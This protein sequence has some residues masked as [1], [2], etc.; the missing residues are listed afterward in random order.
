MC[1]QSVFKQRV[2]PGAIVCEHQINRI[3]I[4]KGGKIG[5]RAS[6]RCPFG[7]GRGDAAVS[8]VLPHCIQKNLLVF[9]SVEVIRFQVFFEAL[10]FKVRFDGPARN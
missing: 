8:G 4:L 1:V 2:Q 5:V 7:R 6:V 3:A 10:A 9:C